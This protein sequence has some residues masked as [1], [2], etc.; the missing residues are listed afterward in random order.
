M[1]TKRIDSPLKPPR[2][3]SPGKNGTL[4]YIEDQSLISSHPPSERSFMNLNPL[5]MK[6]SISNLQMTY[7]RT[8]SPLLFNLEKT[9]KG[10]L[11]TITRIHHSDNDIKEADGDATCI[12]HENC[13]IVLYCCD[14]QASLCIKCVKTHHSDKKKHD[15]VE[16]NELKETISLEAKKH[17]EELEDKVLNLEPEFSLDEIQQKGI[18]EISES[19]EILLNVIDDFYSS[20]ITNFNSLTYKNPISQEKKA[21]LEKKKELIND[22]QNFSKTDC[23]SNFLEY[24]QYNFTQK[25]QSLQEKIENFQKQIKKEF[26]LLPKVK[27]NSSVLKDFQNYLL[28][29]INIFFEKASPTE[30]K[31]PIVQISNEKF[32]PPPVQQ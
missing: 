24:F 3:L 28:N 20:F 27:R 2:Q 6:N 30:F 21:I 14:C 8:K 15:Y 5:T 25:I 31:E 9:K 16:I 22:L 13:K 10:T 12:F 4:S 1:S 17:I 23:N 18:N 32:S 7:Y 29:Y 26:K 11:G 19:K